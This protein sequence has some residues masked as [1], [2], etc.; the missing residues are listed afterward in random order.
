MP[1][2]NRALRRVAP[3]ALVAAIIGVLVV[4]GPQSSAAAPTDGLECETSP[5][6][7][8]SLTASGGYISTPDGNSI[9]MWSYGDTGGSFQFPGP[10]L[11]VESGAN[12]TV[13]LHNALSE[14]TSIMFPGQNKVLA[15]GKPAQPE[16]D[17]N[18][19]LSS[20]TTT[21]AANNGSVTYTFVAGAP[22]TYLYQSGTDVQKQQQM[23][24][25][26]AL[27]VRTKGHPD[28]ENGRADSTFDPAHEYLYMLSEVDP[29]AH[30][31][32]ERKRTYNWNN[33]TPRYFMING[34]SMPDTIAPNHAEWLPNQ[35][36][37]ALIHIR[38]YD[39]QTNP[40]PALIRYLNAGTTNYP[41]HPHGSDEQLIAR[42]GHPAQA[43]D[44]KDLSYSNFL[45]DPAPGQ[46]VDT[47]MTWKDAEHWNS[48]TNP[49]PV[50]LP[51][52]QDQIVGPG[53]ETWFSES[54]YLGESDAQLPPG[55]VQNNQCGEYY[56]VA[57]SHALQ[58]AT[59]FGASFGGMMTLIRIDPPAGC[60]GQ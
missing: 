15:G 52:L 26:G 56:H 34:R 49:V 25:F 21:A 31:A 35:P 45:I 6:N 58:Q 2:L 33:Y 7:S 24:L 14:P 10:T 43:P 36:Y 32:V 40:R 39:E 41:F 5:S 60:P 20:L 1:S 37:G 29:D 47:L 48:A 23:G 38:P 57:H 59:N 12:V 53:T 55:V 3:F 51:Q 13:V 28:Q 17:A 54:P 50:P 9:Y 27:V 11:C 4:P 42:D 18:G 8:F 16:N 19:N 44:G 22:G 46:T 30:L